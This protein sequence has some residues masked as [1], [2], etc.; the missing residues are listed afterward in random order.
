[1][2]RFVKLMSALEELVEAKLAKAKE[3]KS[4]RQSGRFRLVA[5][6]TIQVSA[7]QEVLTRHCKL[8]K[9]KQIWALICPPP[10]GPLS[11]GWHS[12]PDPCWLMKVSSLLFDLLEI[13]PNT[14]LQSKK[15]V[16]ALR[17]MSDNYD[18][19][20]PKTKHMSSSDMIDK[21]DTTLRV[22]MS[23]LRQL[24]CSPI[25]ARRTSRMLSASD[26]VK[27]NVILD[28]VILPPE[29]LR[30][31]SYDDEEK[32]GADISMSAFE[33]SDPDVAQHVTPSAMELVAVEKHK[34]KVVKSAPGKSTVQCGGSRL[35]T[36]LPAIFGKI[37]GQGY[38]RSAISD[39]SQLGKCDP[40]VLQLA[41]QHTP[42]V[43]LK[44][45]KTRKSKKSEK[46]KE[47]TLVKKGKAA[48]GSAKKKAVKG[49][50]AKPC[51][52][53]RVKPMPLESL[54]YKPGE[55][56]AQRDLFVQEQVNHGGLSKRDARKA[57]STSL[58][59]AQLLKDLSIAELIKR[60]FIP[61]GSKTN[62]FAETV[63]RSLEAPNVD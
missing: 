48:G 14:K 38:V 51:K 33:G 63:Q 12:K 45:K 32:T 57:W 10:S 5:D 31:E 44:E 46:A 15:V 60:R 26:Q 34:E 4:Q 9:E 19:I 43:A 50:S 35:M 59:R 17:A 28:R 41:M 61:S 24:K 20:F 54:Q 8:K 53:D 49:K 18:A 58:R 47:I 23:M 40:S 2:G 42:K 25:L 22:L 3:E 29:L 56:N 30:G 37:L 55:M 39:A 62:P 1:M 13:C 16:A 36:S 11:Y 27:L 52:K 21:V 6:V 7:I